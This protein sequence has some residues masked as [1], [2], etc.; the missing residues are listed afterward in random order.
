MLLL[1]WSNHFAAAIDAWRVHT[2]PAIASWLKAVGEFEAIC[3][4]A[5]YSWENPDDPFPEIEETETCL[6]GEALG[7][8]LIARGTCVAN[9]VQLGESLRVLLVSGS[10][11]SGKSTLL[12]TVGVN[13]VLAL[14]GATVRAERLRV[15]GRERRRDLA[16]PGFAPGWS[17]P[18]LCRGL[19]DQAACRP[20][21]W[22]SAPVVSP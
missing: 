21:R 19:A 5:A 8:P 15:L 18:V 9:D 7:H 16:H 13:T 4:F 2:G 22:P 14:A 12:R 10:N 20:R 11:M 3:A 1:F 6:D 17:V